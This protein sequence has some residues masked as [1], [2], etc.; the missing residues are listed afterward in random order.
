MFVLGDVKVRPNLKKEFFT[1]SALSV[2]LQLYN[3]GVDQTTMKPELSVRYRLLKQGQ[4]LHEILDEKGSSIQFFSSRRI[5]LVKSF[6]LEGLP[7]GDYQ[8]EVIV[9][10]LILNQSLQVIEHFR[11]V[12]G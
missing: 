9:K 6:A 1:D 8:L 12:S 2:Y 7:D 4:V 5:V 3:A 11:A 10:D